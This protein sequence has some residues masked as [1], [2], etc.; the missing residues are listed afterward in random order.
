MK[1]RLRACIWLDRWVVEGGCQGGR[2][3]IRDSGVSLEEV[4][5]SGTPEA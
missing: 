3:I 4:F 2:V 5:F 1:D